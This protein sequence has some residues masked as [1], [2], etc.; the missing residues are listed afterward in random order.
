MP[1]ITPTERFAG[2]NWLT[3]MGQICH[4]CSRQCDITSC[5]AQREIPRIFFL[6]FS[7]EGCCYLACYCWHLTAE[8]AQREGHFAVQKDICQSRQSLGWKSERNPTIFKKAGLGKM[9]DRE[10]IAGFHTSEE[11]LVLCAQPQIFAKIVHRLSLFLSASKMSH[12][13]SSR[14]TCIEKDSLL[15]LLNNVLAS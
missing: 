7:P 1:S 4:F 8:K 14:K 5:N 6:S 10:V 3:S 13:S 15:F 2:F 11:S 12:R 9:E